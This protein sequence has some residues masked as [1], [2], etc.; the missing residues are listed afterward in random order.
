MTA[1][2]AP[3]AA[4]PRPAPL[5]APDD[6]GRLAAALL[7]A[8]LHGTPRRAS[9]M[10]GQADPKYR[11]VPGHTF[12]AEDMRDHLAARRTWAVTL[13]DRAS[14][15]A[16]AGC[17]DYDA[18]GERVILDALRAAQERGRVAFAIL[19]PG[20]DGQHDGGH[21]WQLYARPAAAEDVAADLAALPGA[22]GEIFPSGSPIRLPLG[23]HRLKR[24]RGTLVLQDGRR[25]TLDRP[26]ELVAA[27]RALLDLERNAPPPPAPKGARRSSSGAEL[28]RYDPA[29]WE[30]VAAELG[31]ALMA[32][33]RYQ[34]IFTRR[35]QLAALALGQRITL[36]TAE[37]PKDS[38]SEQVA[39]LV[40][41][42]ITTGGR[43]AAGAFVP[44]LGAPPLAE[45][46]AVALHWQDALRP[47]YRGYRLDVDRLIGKAL[48]ETPGY[49][50][51][52]TKHIPGVKAAAPGP[53]SEQRHRGRP[54]GA[55]AEQVERLGCYLAERLGE[56]VTRGELAAVLG[57]KLRATSC[58]LAALRGA[59]G[60]TVTI[61]ARGRGGLLVE[62][63][64]RNSLA[65]TMHAPAAQEAAE[66]AAT[67]E[68]EIGPVLGS[69]PAPDLTPC[70]APAA[71]P[72]AAGD[73]LDLEALAA[74]VDE[75]RAHI[76]AQVRRRVI[77]RGPRAGLVIESPRRAT[78]EAVA[79]LL[80]DVP[81]D[82]LAEAWAYSRSW[83]RDAARFATAAPP[84]L[85]AELRSVGRALHLAEQPAPR[86]WAELDAGERERL[87]ARK[88]GRAEGDPVRAEALAEAQ[89]RRAI[90]QHRAA[91][92]RQK[93]NARL[94]RQL[95]DELRR[96][97]LPDTPPP[98]ERGA[99]RRG[100]APDRA[101]VAQARAEQEAACYE[102]LDRLYGRGRAQAA[103]A[104]PRP[105][106]PVTPA[107]PAGEA[108]RLAEARRR[109]VDRAARGESLT[110]PG[111]VASCAD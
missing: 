102:A 6:G 72:P 66:G 55:R 70:P 18:G 90:Q 83:Q 35:P 10:T 85:Y 100:K 44:G 15:K 87:A 36:H 54:A 17:R 75:A 82:A 5:P 94:Q 68:T 38:G 48:A 31:A 4:A 26:A 7:A 3:R 99:G 45:I 106:P 101:L 76:R 11:D 104:R 42:L 61:R 25:F 52:A 91:V 108:E 98:A 16:R 97:G 79:A 1:P 41:N 27:V 81:P 40:H 32:S 34:H 77:T 37:G 30:G 107:T 28:V 19:M 71:A 46:R 80:P 14:G 88:M 89:H 95:A 67:R 22:K 56:R 51:E 73:A 78:L 110:L 43:D 59:E 21:V 58:Y 65:E 53:L 13:A 8:V 2:V 96:R 86:P 39:V 50:P 60:W 49:Q 63:C 24:T 9:T 47:G 84:A 64:A 33:A 20:A 62:K 105:A 92:R 109:L 23:Y 69:T 29:N 57:V 111:K 74:R 103:A 12:T 93:H